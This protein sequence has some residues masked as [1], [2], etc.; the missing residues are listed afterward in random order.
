MP[1][2]EASR[3]KWLPDLLLESHERLETKPE[4]R[5]GRGCREVEETL[6]GSLHDW[7]VEG[8]C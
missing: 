3:G 5:E 4:Q 1:N 6:S 8:H 7:G 2:P